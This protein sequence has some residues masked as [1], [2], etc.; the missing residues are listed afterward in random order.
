MAAP[1][2]F[3]RFSASWGSA[4]RSPS[5]DAVSIDAQTPKNVFFYFG[6]A[7]CP[8]C[9]A[10]TPE[11]P[12][13]IA[14]QLGSTPKSDALLVYVA[15]DRTADELQKQVGLLATDPAI[16][17]AYLESAT[18][19]AKQLKTHFGAFAGNEQASLPGVT[20]KF[21]IPSLF[22]VKTEEFTVEKEYTSLVA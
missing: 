9:T 7:W 2:E 14:A 3:A 10:C 6:S 4:C 5:N 21:G 8:D 19:A 15:S 13:K 17:T 11:V 22:W 1:S 20:R 12:A 16:R 18:D